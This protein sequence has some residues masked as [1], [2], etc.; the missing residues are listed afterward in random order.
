MTDEGRTSNRLYGTMRALLVEYANKRVPQQAAP[1]G[2]VD[3]QDAIDAVMSLAS[4]LDGNAQAGRLSANDAEFMASMLM[5]IRDHIRPL[6]PCWVDRGQ[7]NED[8]TTPDLQE[9]VDALR[10]SRNTRGHQG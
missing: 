9:M 4:F 8:G 10:Q 3:E 5:V 2:V 7:G 1:R 6:P